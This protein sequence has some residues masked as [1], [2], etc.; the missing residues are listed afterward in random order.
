MGGIA[1]VGIL[2][3]LFD[4]EVLVED[5]NTHGTQRRIRIFGCRWRLCRFFHK[6]FDSAGLVHVHHAK[7]T[8]L[9]QWH[10]DTADGDIRGLFH[11]IS[12]HGTVVHLVDV[13]TG[14]NQHIL[15]VMGADD[16]DVLEN[17]V[18]GAGIPGGL[19]TLL[20]RQ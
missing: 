4:Q 6:T 2:D 3:Q 11:V 19:D 16:I 18:G 15:R 5:V 8:G 12:E 13:V 17:G 7:G 14:E 10:L 1:R 9:L 20:R